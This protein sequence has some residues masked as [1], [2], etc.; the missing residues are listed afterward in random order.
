MEQEAYQIDTAVLVEDRCK[1]RKILGIYKIGSLERLEDLPKQ[2]GEIIS[3]SRKL[4]LFYAKPIAILN[5]RE[6]PGQSHLLVAK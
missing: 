6:G 2:S 4:A 5:L 3:W 1:N